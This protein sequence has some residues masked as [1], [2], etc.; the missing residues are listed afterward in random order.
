MLHYTKI[1]Y[2]ALFMDVTITKLYLN[3]NSITFYF[4]FNY[5]N[6]ISD[7]RVGLPQVFE[8]THIR[9]S[10]TVLQIPSICF[11]KTYILRKAQIVNLLPAR[12]FS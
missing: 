9:Y 5:F 10:F 4:F 2:Q 7:F 1:Y 6:N 3:H 12:F 8:R 11:R